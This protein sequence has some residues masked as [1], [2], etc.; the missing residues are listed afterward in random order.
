MCFNGKARIIQTIQN[1]KQKNESIDYFDLNWNLLDFRQNFP[2]SSKPYERP[3]SLNQ[4]IEYAEIL[5]EGEIFVRI[6]FY[7]INK[8]PVFSEF[9]FYSDS[10][11]AEFEPYE[12]DLKLGSFIELPIKEEVK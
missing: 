5:S 12:W 8:K 1:D 2:N 11:T 3:E 4:M 7:E 6:D 9:T 10:G